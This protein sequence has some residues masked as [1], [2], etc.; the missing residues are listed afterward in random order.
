MRQ[1]QSTAEVPP[2]CTG[3]TSTYSSVSTGAQDQ[4]GTPLLN[5][6]FSRQ[7]WPETVSTH[8]LAA[9]LLSNVCAGMQ[10]FTSSRDSHC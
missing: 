9:V 6:F 4:I 1:Y 2:V 5:S 10:Q 7:V 8:A 3:Y